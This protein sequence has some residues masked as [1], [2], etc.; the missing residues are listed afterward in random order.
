MKK[1]RDGRYGRDAAAYR[2][3]LSRIV[4]FRVGWECSRVSY[5]KFVSMSLLDTTCQGCNGYL[6][7]TGER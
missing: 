5:I 6:V 1:V 4:K 3:Q 2:F 7:R